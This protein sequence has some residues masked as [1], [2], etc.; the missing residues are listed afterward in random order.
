[1]DEWHWW[2]RAK[3]QTHRNKVN[4]VHPYLAGL[5]AEKGHGFMTIAR[6]LQMLEAKDPKALFDQWMG[7]GQA[8]GIGLAQRNCEWREGGE[9]CDQPVAKR[10]AKYCHHHAGIKA[11]ERH[12]RYNTLRRSRNDKV[13]PLDEANTKV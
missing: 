5:D 10:N 12:T 3:L 13:A 1:V 4:E 8:R 7:Q 9:T 2:L 6:V 11:R